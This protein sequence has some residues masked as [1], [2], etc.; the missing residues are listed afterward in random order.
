M[1]F[2]EIRYFGGSILVY[3]AFKVIINFWN[4]SIYNHLLGMGFKRV[5]SFFFSSTDM[6]SMRLFYEALH[7]EFSQVT[8]TNLLC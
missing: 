3:G 7:A 8:E 2:A 4:S 6:R 1:F 5:T